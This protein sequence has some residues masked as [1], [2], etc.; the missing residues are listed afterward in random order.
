MI[1]INL[2]KAV[3]LNVNEYDA[4]APIYSIFKRTIVEREGT[5]WTFQCCPAQVQRLRLQLHQCLGTLRA[6]PTSASQPPS[7]LFPGNH[8]APLRLRTKAFHDTSLPLK[9][10]IPEPCC[11]LHMHC[12]L[13]LYMYS[14]GLHSEACECC[15]PCY[16]YWQRSFPPDQNN[17]PNCRVLWKTQHKLP[18]PKN[19]SSYAHSSCM[20]Y[21]P[22]RA[23][24]TCIPIAKCCSFWAPD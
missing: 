11:Q 19:L 3:I 1:Q 18:C 23:Y 9:F 5:Q 13:C 20:P 17:C 14:F 16:Q 15:S 4:L 22:A 8:Q 2:E 12:I 24:V 10:S 21:S 6:R 7:P